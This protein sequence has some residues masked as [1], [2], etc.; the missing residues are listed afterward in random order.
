[1]AKLAVFRASYNLW[2]KSYNSL[3]D[4]GSKDKKAKGTKKHTIKR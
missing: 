1:M 4:D 3:I 2:F